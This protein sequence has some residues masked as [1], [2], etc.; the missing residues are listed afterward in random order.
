LLTAKALHALA[1]HVPAT[2][3]QPA[4]I[5][6]S[7]ARATANAASGYGTPETLALAIVVDNDRAMAD[8]IGAATRESFALPADEQRVDLADRLSTLVEL[9]AG[10][11][12][13]AVAGPTSQLVGDTRGYQHPPVAAALA[14]AAFA[15][16]DWIGWADHYLREYALNGN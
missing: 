1:D 14:R 6:A 5:A 9:W 2:A 4:L 15:N 13:M 7:D 16:V 11:E 10:F 3:P 8:A 12:G